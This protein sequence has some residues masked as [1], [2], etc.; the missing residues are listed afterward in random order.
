MRH[1]E[2]DDFDAI[3]MREAVDERVRQHLRACPDC[4][5]RL[6]HEARVEVVLQESLRP[7]SKRAP[8]LASRGWSIAWTAAAVLGVIAA[9]AWIALSSRPKPPPHSRASSPAYGITVLAERDEPPGLIDPM[10]YLPGYMSGP[11]EPLGM[12]SSAP[13]D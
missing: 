11:P 10:T 2:Q 9:A 7:A 5:A 13:A 12:E 6:A 8:R 1:L 4:A 3:V